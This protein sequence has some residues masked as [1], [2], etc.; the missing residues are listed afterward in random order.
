MMILCQDPPTLHTILVALG[1]LSERERRFLARKAQIVSIGGWARGLALDPSRRWTLCVVKDSDVETVLHECAHALLRHRGSNSPM[2]EVRVDALVRGWM[3][4]PLNAPVVHKTAEPQAHI[5]DGRVALSC[6]LCHRPSRVHSPWS[7]GAVVVLGLS[8]SSCACGPRLYELAHVSGF[9]CPQCGV[10][11]ITSIFRDAL[12]ALALWRRD[13]LYG[14][15][16]W[17]RSGCPGFLR[18]L[19][20]GCRPTF[21][22]TWDQGGRIVIRCGCRARSVVELVGNEAAGSNPESSALPAGIAG[23]LTPEHNGPE[24]IGTQQPSNVADVRPRAG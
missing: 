22:A 10:D 11:G 12:S 18:W 24:R 16:P 17:L 3:R 21:T 1:L 9:G 13:G 7:S 14:L 5:K 20:R 2:N 15:L 8:C 19:K 4:A 23:R 6:S